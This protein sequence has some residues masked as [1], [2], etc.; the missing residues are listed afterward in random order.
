M[1]NWICCSWTMRE[2]LHLCNFYYGCLV[3]KLQ[4]ADVLQK[5]CSEKI[6][7]FTVK[8]LCW[9][10]FLIK[11]LFIKK[12][13]QTQVFCCRIYEIF[14]SIFFLQSTSVAAS[15]SCIKT[16]TVQL[17]VNNWLWIHQNDWLLNALHKIN[18]TQWK[19]L[20]CSSTTNPTNTPRVFHVLSIAF[21][22]SY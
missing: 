8:H 17:S 5:R 15:V 21:P 2:T 20:L 7:N 9:S 16:K 18:I 14:K 11:S 3:Q 12:R 4:L 19:A 1:I 13:L 22:W 6:R 10:L